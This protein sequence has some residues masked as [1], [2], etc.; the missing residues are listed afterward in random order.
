MRIDRCF[1]GFDQ[2]LLRGAVAPEC[3]LTYESPPYAYPSGRHQVKCLQAFRHVFIGCNEFIVVFGVGVEVGLPDLSQDERR[4]QRYHDDRCACQYYFSYIR[5]LSLPTGRPYAI[6]RTQ[7]R[8]QQDRELCSP[9]LADIS[10]RDAEAHH[11]RARKKSPVIC[12]Q[13]KEACR[14]QS[15]DYHPVSV[16]VIHQPGID[17]CFVRPQE[18]NNYQVKDHEDAG[19][20]CHDLCD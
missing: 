18:G 9:A 19:R 6:A 2:R 11:K 12:Q 5:C 20:R 3:R 7:K 14:V 4:R 1:K 17:G 10:Q 13:K 16:R 8:F 15:Y